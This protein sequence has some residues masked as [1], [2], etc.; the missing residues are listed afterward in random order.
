MSGEEIFDIVDSRDRV[1]GQAPRADVH[2]LGLLHRAVHILVFNASGELFLQKRSMSKD[3]FPGTWDSS[4]AGHLDTG[5]DYDEAALRE[6]G[7]ELGVLPGSPL[8]YLFKL[9]ACAETG[10][11]FV[12]VYRTEHEGPFTLHPEEIEGGGWFASGKVTSWIAERPEDFPN[13]FI[14]IWKTYSDR[15]LG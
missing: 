1:I 14:L 9:D 3:T 6:L 2:K 11:E 8:E 13:A 12:Q 15:Y 5:E 10:E 7:E 4:A